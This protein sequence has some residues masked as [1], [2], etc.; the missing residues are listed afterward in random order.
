MRK[1]YLI[2]NAHLDPV[3]LWRWQEGF[4][5]IIATYRS[6]LDRLEEFPDLKFTTACAAYY[7]WIENIDPQMFEE[8]KQRVK[9]GRWNIAG[10]WYIQPDCNTPCGESFARQSLISQ[11]YF[12][13]KFGI[14]AKTGYNV[15]SFGHN[16]N[17]PM[18]LKQSGM[19]NYVFMR[20]GEQDKTNLPTLFNWESADGSSVSAYRLPKDYA[21]REKCD[22]WI[23]EYT[24]KAQEEDM[25][26][27]MFIGIGNHGGGPSVALLDEI[28][29]VGGPTY[30]STLE[31]YFKT[32]DKDKLPLWK[33]ELQ[34]HGVGCYSS[35]AIIKMGNR[36]CEQNLLA[37]EK[38][39][40]LANN[41]TGMKYPHDE[42]ERAWKITLFNQ[43]HD[44]MGGCSIKDA[45]EDSANGHGEVMHI[46]EQYINLAMQKICMAVDTLR[47]ETLPCYKIQ[48]WDTYKV[49]LHGALGTPLVVFNPHTWPVSAEIELSSNAL[50]V[51]DE[52]DVEIPVQKIR[53]KF[54]SAED[55]Y[56]SV[57]K[58]EIPPLG[59]RV[60]RYYVLE[61]S[62]K[63]FENEMLIGE[64][65]IE[66]SKIRVEFDKT[67][68]D[69][70]RFYD[71]TNKKYII[72]KPCSAVVI[73]DIYDSW[74]HDTLTLG[75]TEGNF[76][77]P[78]F[79]VLES[80][81]VR[82]ILRVKTYY[83]NSWIQRDYILLAGSDEVRV[84]VKM[85][86]NEHHKCVKFSFPT[87]REKIIAQIPY[88]T[89][90]RPCDTGE[91][92]FG[93]WFAS[94]DLCVAN[95]GKHGYDT[96]DGFMRM[97]I[98]RTA[99]Y[100]HHMPTYEQDDFCEY[101]DLG[102]HEFM[103]SIYP[104]KDNADAER[105]ATEL[106]SPLRFVNASFHNGELPEMKSCF[107][108]DNNDIV[109]SAIKKCED[110]DKTIVRFVEMNGENSDVNIQIFDKN[111]KTEFT[112][113]SLKTVNEDAKELNLLEWE[114]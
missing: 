6:A 7:E 3:W 36:K 113:N 100:A 74:A 63:N 79:T 56:G 86:F 10:G 72:D 48:D 78:E 27:M 50:K 73:D 109:V 58:A 52:N 39:C 40:M 104:F 26:Y 87:D 51:T 47:G 80:G 95:N 99:I 112:H 12:K 37:A 93:M 71:K 35:Y 1:L 42:L 60:Y 61:K 110:N 11:R 15:D 84:K 103:Y 89:I 94:G 20:P 24:K 34:H 111:I 41:L 62:E 19:D 32:I 96:H 107:S 82:S 64:T 59:Y 102:M 81:N 9:E 70:C 30:Y 46:T 77:S 13:K 49:W 75:E 83:K 45:Y 91:E 29:K 4:A 98:L 17:I 14:C 97:T 66:N 44:I 92:S 22:E 114:I 18:I 108:C 43:F 90:E 31:E 65:F 106:N 101:M 38:L 68:G 55:L 28:K 25:D 33:S 88:G 21:L 2:G 67:T 105:R 8:I 69:I 85:M 54:L 53:S 76:T 23:P 57:F 16:K 5:E